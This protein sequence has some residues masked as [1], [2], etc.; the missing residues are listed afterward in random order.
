MNT[1]ETG[2]G[3]TDGLC[4]GGS[5]CVCVGGLGGGLGKSVD[6]MPQPCDRQDMER[7]QQRV[8]VGRVEWQVQWAQ[9]GGGV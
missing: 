1:R 8:C 2:L 7:A 3:A 6:E 9:V 4:K 5:W